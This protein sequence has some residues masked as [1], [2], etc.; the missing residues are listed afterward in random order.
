MSEKWNSIN[1]ESDLQKLPRNR[2]DRLMSAYILT[3]STKS[4]SLHEIYLMYFN[5][6]DKLFHFPDYGGWPDI[7][8]K[9]IVEINKW[10][11][12]PNKPKFKKT[13]Q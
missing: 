4:K 12:L 9:P 1:K 3:S 8:L 13:K 11:L 2:Y 5:F 6:T 7:T 10:M